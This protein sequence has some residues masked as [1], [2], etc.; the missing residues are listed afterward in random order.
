MGGQSVGCSVRSRYRISPLFKGAF[1]GA[2][3]VFTLLLQALFPVS[4]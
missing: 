3:P 4:R 1:P 2:L